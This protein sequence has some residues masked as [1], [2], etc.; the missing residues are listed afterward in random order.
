MLVPATGGQPKKVEAEL[1]IESP[2]AV[3]SPDGSHLLAVGRVDP[4]GPATD[5]IDWFAI[6]LKD[7]TVIRTGASA[8]LKAQKVLQ[9]TGVI[10]GP[11]DWTGGSVLFTAQNRDAANVWRV[12]VHP[13]TFQLTTAAERLT[14]GTA[15]E[16]L[17]TM[18][19]DGK[20]AFTA[21]DILEDYWALP[22]DANAAVV[23]GPRTQIM[24]NSASD[25]QALSLDGN[26][27]LY[28]SHRGGQSEFRSRD[29]RSGK[30]TLL[31]SSSTD[32]HISS[33][34]ADGSAFM[35]W[36]PGRVRALFLGTTSGGP[37]RKLCENCDYSTL[38]KDGTKH[39]RVVEPDKHTYQLM[40][41]ASGR[42]TELVSSPAKGFG[43]AQ[44][45]PDDQ[46]VAFTTETA[47]EMFLVPVRPSKVDEKELIRVGRRS[48]PGRYEMFRFSP[49]GNTIYY[50]SYEDGNGCIYA[51]RLAA[52]RHPA[53]APVVVQHL[54]E[55]NTWGHPHGMRVGADK[56]VLLMNQGTSNI[57][58][59]Q[60]Q[61]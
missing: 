10:S 50:V 15:Q 25:G 48:P 43:G 58:L 54:H 7:G 31:V 47:E 16:A 8:A 5:A 45:S 60:P 41:I 12:G 13:T 42:S 14:S 46:W 35:Y 24:K 37:P 33:A 44:F 19:R 52:N 55:A 49:D 17:P 2:Y 3:W 27:L 29:L 53:G 51:Q 11:N 59:M 23:K 22:V 28:C 39:L 20:L 56:I 40:D 32:Q 9:D 61:R 38:S 1:T 36:V 18:S 21:I 30:E 57:W 26:T 6:S 34:T 4:K